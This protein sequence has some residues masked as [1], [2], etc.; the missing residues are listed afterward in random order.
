MMNWEVF[1]M[2]QG[3][4]GGNSDS[5]ALPLLTTDRVIDYFMKYSPWAG[6]NDFTSLL[7]ACGQPAAV[8]AARA[9]II[10][11]GKTF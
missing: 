11:P 3:V 8:E 6:W 10:T 2:C 4:G 9:F 7:Y 1:L 5:R